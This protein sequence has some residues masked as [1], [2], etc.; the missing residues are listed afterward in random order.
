LP[1]R[2]FWLP[3]FDFSITFK[4]RSEPDLTKLQGR[5]G[6]APPGLFA[7]SSTSLV[8]TP[9]FPCHEMDLIPRLK[10]SLRRTELQVLLLFFFLFLF[11]IPV[12]RGDGPEQAPAAFFYLFSLWGLCIAVLFAITRSFPGRAAENKEPLDPDHR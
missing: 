5:G 6:P 1:K 12:L 10:Q 7:R 8:P 4:N 11:L 9:S 3:I 2:H